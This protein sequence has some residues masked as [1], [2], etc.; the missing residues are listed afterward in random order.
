MIYLKYLLCAHGN[1]PEKKEISQNPL[2]NIMKQQERVRRGG[3]GG[4]REAKIKS[5]FYEQ[6]GMN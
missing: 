2:R 4:G 3:W 5:S 6:A 1:V